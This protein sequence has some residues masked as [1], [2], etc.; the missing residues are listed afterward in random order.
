MNVIHIFIILYLHF[1][2]LLLKY[3]LQIIMSAI[4]QPI[5]ALCSISKR[6]QL[7]HHIYV[8]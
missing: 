2:R 8:S 1:K 3:Q 7:L 6:L 4:K 5:T